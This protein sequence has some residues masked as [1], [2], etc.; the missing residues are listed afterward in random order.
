MNSS[1]SRPPGVLRALAALAIYYVLFFVFAWIARSDISERIVAASGW[2]PPAMLL[3]IVTAWLGASVGIT[4]VFLFSK[5]QEKPSSA[6]DKDAPVAGNQSQVS[7]L[8]RFLLGGIIV[9]IACNYAAMKWLG[10][11]GESGVLQLALMAT[12]N[13]GILTA[14]TSAGILVARGLREPRYLV[15]AAIVGAITDIFSV[16]AGPSKQVVS[17]DVFP[18]LGYQWGV[19]GQGVIPC[20]GAGDFIFLSLYFVGARRFGLSERKTFMAMIAAFGLG[21]VSL[22]LTGAAIPALP[23]MAT[24]LLL[25]HARQLKA[26]CQPEAA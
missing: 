23:F 20:V 8:I 12:A 2:T 22:V 5:W 17:S 18:Y 15:M 7:Q 26:L 4:V 6:D 13:L 1:L 14:A 11:P 24:L 10:T 25:V 19:F 21:F 9:D 16:Y 3:P